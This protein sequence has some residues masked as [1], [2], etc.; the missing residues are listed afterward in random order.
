LNENALILI[1]I[2]YKVFCEGEAG[3]WKKEAEALKNN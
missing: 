3:G 2:Q 1:I